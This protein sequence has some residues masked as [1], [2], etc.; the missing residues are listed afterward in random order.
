M[1]KEKVKEIKKSKKEIISLD[2]KQEMILQFQNLDKR[3][4]QVELKLNQIARRLG[5]HE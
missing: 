2:E 1:S 3:V 5:L 4:S